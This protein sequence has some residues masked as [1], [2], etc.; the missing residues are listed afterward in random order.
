MLHRKSDRRPNLP[1]LLEQDLK[2]SGDMRRMMMP[3]EPIE[4]GQSQRERRRR[5]ESQWAAQ[6]RMPITDTMI[7]AGSHWP[8]L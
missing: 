6:T 2:A 7:P 8:S 1:F 4:P 5:G 3:C